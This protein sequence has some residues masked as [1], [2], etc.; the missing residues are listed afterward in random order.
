M[1][2]A[3]FAPFHV[4]DKWG[5]NESDLSQVIWEAM[6]RQA[7]QTQVFRNLLF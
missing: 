6:E 1:E 7:S 3:I 4:P 2:W 5:S